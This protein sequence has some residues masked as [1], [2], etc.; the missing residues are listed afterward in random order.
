NG[1]KNPPVL[2]LYTP[3]NHQVNTIQE[4]YPDIKT[5]DLGDVKPYPYQS[6]DGL[7]IHAYLTLPPGKTPHN[8]PTVIF[9]HG[10]PEAR[11]SMAD[12]DWWAQFMA[13]R[14]YAVLQPNFRGSSG[15]GW[16]F[17]K[18][19]DGEWAGKVQ[20]DLQDGVQKLIAAGIADPKRICIVGASYGGCRG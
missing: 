10:G 11:D 15:Y 7:T 5:A 14:G 18:A 16:K 4:A 2:S 9:P 17:I 20:Y 3:S 13:T 1:P 8:L 6:R 12:F 19:G